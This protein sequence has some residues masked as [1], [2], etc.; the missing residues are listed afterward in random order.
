MNSNHKTRPWSLTLA[1][2]P[3]ISFTSSFSNPIL[4]LAY[5]KSL[6]LSTQIRGNT[7]KLIS[8]STMP[9]LYMDLRNPGIYT[10]QVRVQMDPYHLISNLS[11]TINDMGLAVFFEFD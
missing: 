1:D 8:Y 5:G 6:S 7:K 2:C 11:V 4:Y 9:E 10:N 3:W